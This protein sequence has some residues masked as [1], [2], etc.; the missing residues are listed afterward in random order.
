MNTIVYI[1]Y[2]SLICDRLQRFIL[3]DLKADA[4]LLSR[5]SMEMKTYLCANHAFMSESLCCVKKK[6]KAPCITILSLTDQSRS[7]ERN[8]KPTHMAQNSI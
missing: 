3:F 4:F 5:L 7:S 1:A 8:F 6:K 2:Y